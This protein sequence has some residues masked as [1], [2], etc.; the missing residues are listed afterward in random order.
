MP[1]TV[2][3]RIEKLNLDLDYLENVASR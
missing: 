2:P 3:T 1:D